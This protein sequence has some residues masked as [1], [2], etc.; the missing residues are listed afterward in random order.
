VVSDPRF[1]SI[2][3]HKKNQSGLFYYAADW[4]C[5]RQPMTHFKQSDF[6]T[7]GKPFNKQIATFA[8]R[9]HVGNFRMATSSV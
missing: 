9:I 5:Y 2:S 7:D 3:S 4:L 6:D 8:L 1:D